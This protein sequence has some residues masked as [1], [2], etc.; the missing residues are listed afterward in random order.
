MRAVRYLVKLYEM[1]ADHGAISAFDSYAN[2][3]YVGT[4]RG[5]LFR[6]FVEGLEEYTVATATTITTAPS[7]TDVQK[8]NSRAKE[9]ENG[10]NT[11]RERS[12]EGS[13]LTASRTPLNDTQASPPLSS[14]AQAPSGNERYRAGAPPALGG[15]A[16][17]LGN[18]N[19]SPPSSPSASPSQQIFTSLVGR[20][21]VSLGGSRVD[22]LQHSRT[23]TALFVLCAQKLTVWHSQQLTPLYE[24]TD[25]VRTFFVSQPTVAVS[26]SP[27]NTR[28]DTGIGH[29]GSSSAIAVPDL[30]PPSAPSVAVGVGQT[31]AGDHPPRTPTPRTGV[32]E[33]RASHGENAYTGRVSVR[34][35]ASGRGGE[36]AE[37]VADPPQKTPPPS[38]APLTPP[39]PPPPHHHSPSPSSSALPSSSSLLSP[40]QH[41]PHQSHTPT[42][43]RLAPYRI[44]VID[45]SGK[46]VRL[47][48]LDTCAAVIAPQLVQELLLPEPA[49]TIVTHG[50]IACVGM[51]RE[52]SL[53]S[54]R[55]GAARS[56]LRLNGTR[57][58][59]VVLGGDEE[60]YM[61][62]QNSLFA[63]S[64]RAMPPAAARIMGRTI[65]VGGEPRGVAVRYPFLF[66]F[67]EAECEVYSLFEDVVEERLPLP[68][69]LFASQ[70][71]RGDALFVA[72]KRALWMASLYSL[73]QQLADL[74]EHDRVEEAFQLLAAQRA[75]TSLDLQD[76]ELELHV[77]AGFT[78][79]HRCRPQ[80]A[81]QHFNDHID[82][83]DLLL[84]LPECT[85]PTTPAAYSPALQ[86]VL[87]PHRPAQAKYRGGTSGLATAVVP[88]SAPPPPPPV[89]LSNTLPSIGKER[90]VTESEESGE[91]SSSSG[92]SRDGTLW[93]GWEG[94][95]PYNTYADAGGLRKAWL[96]TFETYPV[97]GEDTP[98]AVASAKTAKPSSTTIAAEKA[99]GTHF[100]SDALVRIAPGLGPVTADQFLVRCWATFKDAVVHYFFSRLPYAEADYARAMELAV[101]VLSL[102][103][104][105]F[106]SAYAVVGNGAH[107]R[108][109]DCY[110]LLVSLREYRLAACLLFRRGYVD[111]AQA[112]LRQRVYLSSYLAEL[113]SVARTRLVQQLWCCRNVEEAAP[114]IAHSVREATATWKGESG[115]GT[116]PVAGRSLFLLPLRTARLV[117]SSLLHMPP[118]KEDVQSGEVPTDAARA[119]RERIYALA[120]DGYVARATEALSAVHVLRQDGDARS[121]VTRPT[122]A[123]V[124]AAAIHAPVSVPFFGPTRLID[125][126]PLPLSSLPSSRGQS[127]VE[128]EEEEE[129]DEKEE[130]TRKEEKHGEYEQPPQP[131]TPSPQH[132]S[133]GVA[134]PTFT[135]TTGTVGDHAG[136]AYCPPTGETADGS[137]SLLPHPSQ[138]SSQSLLPSSLAEVWYLTERLD[139][140]ALSEALRACPA[141]VHSRDEEGN[142]L[143]HL[144]LSLLL[145]VEPTAAGVGKSSA[146]RRSGGKE[147]NGLHSETVPLQK[148][149]DTSGRDVAAHAEAV[150]HLVLS[151]VVVLVNAGCPVDAINVHGMSC[152]D[153]AALFG[154]GG[155]VDTVVALLL[156]TQNTN[157]VCRE[158][159][160]AAVEPHT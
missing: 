147:R 154:G 119:L 84:H 124:A 158:A 31:E 12:P 35:S 15:R 111:A 66:V 149:A 44:S 5:E 131:L 37:D 146:A 85:V 40:S 127:E 32:Q 51:R 138:A 68:G 129:K 10:D 98:T 143:L 69:G 88:S 59:L 135:A 95:C 2:D 121:V 137:S 97:C 4:D 33:A 134:L 152:I 114:L 19:A 70:L 7:R 30:V 99:R 47:Y 133:L 45:G 126:P 80:E 116:L 73:R 122:A 139:L 106:R 81:M 43:P 92:S 144:A 55:D 76:L 94:P 24:V 132:T 50:S 107:L 64:M 39:S 3:L 20:A 26:S 90:T 57:P 123:T 112:M 25:N 79:L 125:A 148:A 56:V 36:T 18:A 63:V 11:E 6:F 61:R 159:V 128:E 13:L 16:D 108:V 142:T 29:P 156:A 8:G 93:S 104:R 21:M 115:Q 145:L 78:Y 74:V 117:A 100:N 1:P 17:R 22:Q 48:A 141:A 58:P 86:S 60:V 23:Q 14:S 105:D 34:S 46:M 77:M 96:E 52:Y 71:A 130:H 38:H 91:V 157:A 83:R 41:Q 9:S 75:R 62:Y 118:P 150:L 65:H 49:Q 101:L 102:E 89:T 28:A 140:L 109:E 87:Y 42:P 110:D 151:L 82:P 153:V 113:H 160:M 136:K 54:L 155:Y 53:L 72:G 27:H 120:A 67:T 103:R